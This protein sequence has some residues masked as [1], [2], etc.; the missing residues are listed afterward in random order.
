VDRAG[1]ESWLQRYVKAWESN[2][3]ADIAALF[4]NDARYFTSPHRDPWVGP[5]TIAAGWIDRKDDP[6]TWTFRWEVLG[7]DGDLSFVRGWTTYTNDPDYSNLWVIRLSADGRC[8]EFIE[9]W[10]EAGK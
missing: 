5:D 4:T 1:I 8:S 2:D 9:W 7:M 10:M 3:P 6:G